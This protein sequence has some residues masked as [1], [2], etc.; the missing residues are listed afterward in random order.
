M[1]W[2]TDKLDLLKRTALDTPWQNRVH[3]YA[4]CEVASM[5]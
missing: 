4:V 5:P 1:Y 2:M 3:W